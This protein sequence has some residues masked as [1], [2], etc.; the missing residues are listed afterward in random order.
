M[1]ENLLRIEE[2]LALLT[3]TRY[4]ADSSYIKRTISFGRNT[5][6]YKVEYAPEIAFRRI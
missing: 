4:F 2:S 5:Y 6:T 3:L 1:N